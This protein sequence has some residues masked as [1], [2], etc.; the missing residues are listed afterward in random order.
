MYPPVASVKSPERETFCTNDINCIRGTVAPSLVVTSAVILQAQMTL[1]VSLGVVGCTS[2]TSESFSRMFCTI[3][4][5]DSILSLLRCITETNEEIILT[6][7]KADLLSGFA[8]DTGSHVILFIEGPRYG[9]ILRIW[10][11][12][13]DFYPKLKPLFSCSDRY[14]TRIY[15]GKQHFSRG[16]IL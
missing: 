15:S 3:R 8:I 5:S 13:E 9:H 7:N 4:D 11:M 1:D 14:S 10:E 2:H 6:G 12:T 16:I